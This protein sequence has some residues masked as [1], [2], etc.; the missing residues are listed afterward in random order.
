MVPE[1]IGFASSTI[2]GSGSFVATDSATCGGRGVVR[3][4]IVSWPTPSA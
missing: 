1:N 4:V 2:A 3:I